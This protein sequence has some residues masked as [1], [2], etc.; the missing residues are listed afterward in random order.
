L[1]V[2]L[3]AGVEQRWFGCGALALVVVGSALDQ[4]E[5]RNMAMKHQT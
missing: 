1:A 5:Q 4:N 2:P 3:Q